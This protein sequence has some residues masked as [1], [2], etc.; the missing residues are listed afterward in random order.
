VIFGELDTVDEP[1]R[2]RAAL[3]FLR[4]GADG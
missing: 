4:D 1:D 2:V 3:Q